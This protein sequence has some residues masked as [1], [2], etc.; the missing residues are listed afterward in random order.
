LSSSGSLSEEEF[1]VL[2]DTTFLLTKQ[3][4]DK[5]ISASL[6]NYQEELAAL[7]PN[8]SAGLPFTVKVLP[9]KISKGQNYG[10][11][12]YW[13][14]DFPSHFDNENIFTFRVVL[15]WGNYISASLILSGRYF[16][17]AQLDFV[18]LNHSELS[19]SINS[20]P[21]P[22]EF[23]P[24]NLISVNSSNL[25]QINLISVNSSNLKQIKE[26]YKNS[27]FVKLSVKHDLK[28]IEEISILCSRDLRNML[29][30]FNWR[31]I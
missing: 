11:L 31:N 28:Q 12:P 1:K 13:V 19:Y 24:K 21:W 22:I 29:S 20:T 7:Y 17:Q 16:E 15:W 2:A 27:K 23:E 4:I 25:K 8:F 30:M 26:H 14:V 18:K 9:K 5:K 10:G 6:L 3:E